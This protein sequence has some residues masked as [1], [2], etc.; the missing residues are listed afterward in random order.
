[1]K[2]VLPTRLSSVDTE[3]SV[4]TFL[5]A[6]TVT[7]TVSG[8]IRTRKTVIERAPATSSDATTRYFQLY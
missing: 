1:M 4:L 3:D 7:S 6:V 5:C 2:R 8:I